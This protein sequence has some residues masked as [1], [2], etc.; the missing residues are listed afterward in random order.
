V[1]TPIPGTNIP[2]QPLPKLTMYTLDLALQPA[3]LED[4]NGGDPRSGGISIFGGF[5]APAKQNYHF[6]ITAFLQDMLLGR[7]IDRGTYIA[8]IDTTNT[9]TVDI[10]ETPQVAAR[11]IAVGTTKSSPYKIVLNIIYTKILKA[12]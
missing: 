2:L 3:L 9:S 1:I 8:P 6:I 11:T 7:I 12:N 5:Y 4:A 10:A